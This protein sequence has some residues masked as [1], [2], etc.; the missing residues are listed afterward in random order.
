MLCDP[1]YELKFN[2]FS[3]LCDQKYA[4]ISQNVDNDRKFFGTKEVN[5]RSLLV[6]DED[7]DDDNNHI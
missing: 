1:R 4:L 5:A 6:E 7:A 2:Y 3:A